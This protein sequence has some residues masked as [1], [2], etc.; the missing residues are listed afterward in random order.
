MLP[1]PIFNVELLTSARRARY[2]LIRALY[3][4][5]LLVAVWFVYQT[6]HAAYRYGQVQDDIH[7]VAELSAGFFMTFAWMQ[8]L[9]VMILCPA[10]VAGAVAS[11]RERRTIEYLFA[12]QLSNA[13]IVLGKLAARVIHVIYLLL[14]GVPVLALM[15][16]L[17]GIAP[18]A[19][20]V[21]FIVT[22]SSMLTVC[23]LAMAISVWSMRAREAVTKAYLLLFVLVAL[24][25]LL[26]SLRFAGPIISDSAIYNY[27][28]A[29]ISDQLVLANPFATMTLAMTKA[30]G[31]TQALGFDLVWGL[32]RN[33]CIATILS[34]GAATLAVRRVHLRQR[35]KSARRQWRFS[36]WI[37]PAVGRR[38]MLWKEIFAEPA[39]ARLGVLGRI[40]VTLIVLGV[41]APTICTFYYAQSIGSGYQSPAQEYIG[42]ALMMGTI[43]GCGILLM[44]AARAAGSIASER[45]RDCWVSL[46]STPLDPKEIIW[47]KIAGSVW[48][49]RWGLALL[50][51]IWGLGVIIEPTSIM[52][53]VFILATF[54]ILAFYAAALGVRFSL[55]CKTSLRAMGATL[56]VALFVGG[57]YLFCC[58]PVFI[59]SNPG[60]GAVLVAAPCV[61]YLLAMPGIYFVEH[62]H[63]GREGSAFVAAYFLGTFG[64]LVAGFFLTYR[65]IDGFDAAN[66]RSRLRT[67]SIEDARTPAGEALPPA[68]A[69]ES[70][71]SVV[72][73][74]VVDDRDR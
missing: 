4:L 17:G 18:E 69:S 72:A 8:L 5:V 7:S 50:V 71:A 64:Y 56:A 58:M 23:S 27:V 35:V 14:V 48:A 22:L 46:L 55:R 24:P 29:P 30:S 37:R 34:A 25:P 16:M 36:H 43:L 21:L 20:L 13:E 42:Y 45:E 67:S 65:S 63:M 2:F 1:G 15:M 3:G 51:L 53:V 33:Q 31:A 66:G 68:A 57:L 6:H 59:A 41:L 62:G 9:A 60:E 47:A 28:V 38:A 40:T 32:V 54:L 44:V 26:S 70:S 10:M 49:M 74:T 61:P 19:L 11:E 73:A 52:P 12:S 39:A